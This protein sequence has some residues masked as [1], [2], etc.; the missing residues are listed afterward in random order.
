M[1]TPRIFSLEA[2]LEYLNDDEFC[3]ITPKSIRLRKKLL[4]R[5]ERE[6]AEKQRKNAEV[7]S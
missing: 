5:G 2:A 1:K 4:N 3:E 6:R 7:N